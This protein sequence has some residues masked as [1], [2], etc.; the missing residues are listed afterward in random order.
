M[1]KY[2]KLYVSEMNKND[3]L[4]F[5]NIKKDMSPPSL[6]SIDEINEWIEQDFPYLFDRELY[7]KEKRRNSV[8]VR[9]T[10]RE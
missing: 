3:K 10:L 1:R 7:E 9:F 8:N 6:R 5:P 2:Y 4:N